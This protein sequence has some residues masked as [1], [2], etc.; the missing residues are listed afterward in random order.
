MA[1]VRERLPSPT[2][3]ASDIV[4][5]RRE[6]D[7]YHPRDDDSTRWPMQPHAPSLA[8]LYD[9]AHDVGL[10]RTVG[11]RGSRGT[12][13]ADGSVP[14]QTLGIAS[15]KERPREKVAAAARMVA[16]ALSKLRAARDELDRALTMM[17]RRDYE[18]LDRK[19]GKG[20]SRADL[21]A[22]RE[23]QAARRRQR[24]SFG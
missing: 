1:R 23:A 9:L 24:G 3:V 20:V 6:L 2:T 19:L 22:S 17:D 16:E 11:E 8:E 12:V 5:I 14:G 21:Q 4:N 18:P 7:G 13:A 10:D 15:E